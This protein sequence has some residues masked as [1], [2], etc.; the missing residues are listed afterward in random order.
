MCGADSCWSEAA[1][2]RKNGVFSPNEE[3]WKTLSHLLKQ[4]NQRKL[5]YLH[6]MGDQKSMTLSEHAMKPW[7][8]A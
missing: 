4:L 3:A 2:L 1:A 6:M 5:A 7:L 8:R